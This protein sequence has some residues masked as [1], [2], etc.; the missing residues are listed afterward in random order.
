MWNVR[1]QGNCPGNIRGYP[2]MM[3]DC[4]FLHQAVIIRDTLANIQTDIFR[5]VILLAQPAK[6]KNVDKRIM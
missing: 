1:E 5:P 3:Q 4:K 2:D 6:L